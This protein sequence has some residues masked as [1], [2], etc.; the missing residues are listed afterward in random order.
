MKMIAKETL[1]GEIQ[2]RINGIQEHWGFRRQGGI[3][4]IPTIALDFAKEHGRPVEENPNILLQAAVA[5]GKYVALIQL[6]E[7]HDILVDCVPEGFVENVIYSD[8]VAYSRYRRMNRV[9]Q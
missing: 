7:E 4:Q 3:N 9:S 1:R 8:G 6:A 2:A 5:F